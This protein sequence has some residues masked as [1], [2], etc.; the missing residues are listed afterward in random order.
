MNRFVF[1]LDPVLRLRERAEVEAQRVLAAL[2]RDRATI[3]AG[4]RSRHTD[5]QSARADLGDRLSASGVVSV[6]GV[7]RQATATLDLMAG[8]QREAVRLAAL[9]RQ[10]DTARAA[11]AETTAARRAIE[12][13]RERRHQAWRAE[14]ARADVAM[15][16]EQT[17]ARLLHEERSKAC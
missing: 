7:R 17:A 8:A 11:L 9:H 1:K 4:L 15:A 14:Q 2:E 3:E 12:R 6:V 13:L 10:I 5:A 16:D